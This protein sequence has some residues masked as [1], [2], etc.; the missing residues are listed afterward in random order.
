L[1]YE[2]VVRMFEQ[3]WEQRHID[4]KLLEQ[5]INAA[6]N[7]TSTAAETIAFLNYRGSVGGSMSSTYANAVRAL[8]ALR[9]RYGLVEF[10]AA[11]A[12]LRRRCGVEAP[13]KKRVRKKPAAKTARRHGSAA[14]L[15]F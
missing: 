11:V 1:R 4:P 9:T 15:E 10:R 6:S 7:N 12:E 8:A 14:I 3:L 5:A 13:K 2:K